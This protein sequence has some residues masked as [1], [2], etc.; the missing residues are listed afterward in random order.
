MAGLASR[1]TTTSPRRKSSPRC[2]R[3]QRTDVPGSRKRAA[4]GF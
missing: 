4:L 2:S 3:G 1:K